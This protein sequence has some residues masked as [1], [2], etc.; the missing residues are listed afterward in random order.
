MGY[1][2]QLRIEVIY[3]HNYFIADPVPKFGQERKSEVPKRKKKFDT[4][5]APP[6][7]WLWACVLERQRTYGLTLEEMAGIAGVGYAS[8]RQIMCE[9]PWNWKREVRERVCEYFGINISVVPG[10]GGNIEVNI[11]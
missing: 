6:V 11:K 10:L 2:F 8:M 7:D 5:N 1:K 9:S 4:A 3:P